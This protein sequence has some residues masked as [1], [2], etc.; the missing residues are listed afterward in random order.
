[1][2]ILDSFYRDDESLAYRNVDQN[3]TL[4]KDFKKLFQNLFHLFIELRN[5]F[6]WF[7]DIIVSIYFNNNFFLL[8]N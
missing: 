7:I 6:F 3:K 2:F 8:K 1:M 4:N 5:D